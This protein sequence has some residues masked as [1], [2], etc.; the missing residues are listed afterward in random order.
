MSI[1][2]TPAVVAVLLATLMQSDGEWQPY[3]PPDDPFKVSFLFPKERKVQTQT[4][5]TGT[6]AQ[7]VNA[8]TAS[9][10]YV[11]VVY[12]ESGLK[13]VPSETEKEKFMKGFMRAAQGK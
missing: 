11:A 7:V 4:V 3:S 13:G 2:A 1:N 9:G 6:V 10:L 8:N 12:G 5:S